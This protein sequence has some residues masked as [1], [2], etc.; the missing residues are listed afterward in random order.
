MT[1]CPQVSIEMYDDNMHKSTWSIAIYI[2][3]MK[4]QGELAAT[5]LADL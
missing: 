4:Q 3:N 2:L 5:N 1:N